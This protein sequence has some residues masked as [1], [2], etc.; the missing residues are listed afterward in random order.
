MNRFS[1]AVALAVLMAVPVAAQQ[2]PSF[3]E[4]VDVNVV[5]IDAVVTDPGGNQ[6]LGLDK[7]DFIVRENGRD[8]AVDSVDYFT[9]RKLLNAREQD[10]PFK[11]ERVNE[12]RYFVLFFDKPEGGAMWDQVNL[13]RNAAEEF[14]RERML[15]GDKVA[16]VGHDVRLKVYSDFTGDRGQLL[17]TLKDVPKF[18]LGLTKPGSDAASPSILRNIDTKQMIGNTGTVYEALDLL[19][20]SLR[21]IRGR[22]NLVLFSPGI[23]EPGEEVRDGV[24]LGRSRYY[25]PMMRSLNTANVAVYA[26]NIQ[27]NPGTSSAVHQTL[28]NLASDTS[29]EYFRYLVSFGPALKSV[30]RTNAGYYL[31]SYRTNKTAGTSGFQKVEV[32]VRPQGMRV[33]SRPGYAYG[34]QP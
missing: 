31:I 4:Q 13:A 34:I 16:L 8:V 5:L 25:E 18:G 3:G 21:S 27:R 32:D 19:G 14:V 17:R 6:I 20:N 2:T 30:D 33:K 15:D 26:V 24:L 7:N 12:E 23:Q 29:G 1:A 22:K 9:N 28:E 10:A 11:V